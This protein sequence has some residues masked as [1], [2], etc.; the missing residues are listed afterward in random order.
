[1][2]S[3]TLVDQYLR[4][5]TFSDT[6]RRGYRRDI[7]AFFKFTEG[8]MP[9]A[10]NVRAWRQ[11]LEEKDRTS[12]HVARCLYAIK[13]F[14]EWQEIPI[15]AG[16]REKAKSKVRAPSLDFK[17]PP[18]T[19]SVEEIQRMLEACRTPRD[20]MMLMFLV[21]TGC[22]I[23]ELMRIQL[24]DIDWEAKTVAIIRKGKK[25]RRQ[26][27][28]VSD[29]VLDVMREWIEWRETKS[30]YLLPFSYQELRQSFLELAKRAKVK[31]PRSSLFHNLRHFFVLFQKDAGTKINVISLAAG[32]TSTQITER[33]Y[34]M[35]SPDTIKKQLHLQP[36]E[37]KSEGRV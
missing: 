37:V 24:T 26:I 16:P 32:H 11:S 14:C 4:D 25:G 6:T 13:G 28:M 36:W 9:T 8:E 10:E 15:F 18:E 20:K 34:G 3:E 2:K 19:R 30:K 22:R 5:Q 17:A 12:S 29:A 7:L 1:M 31:F 33:V 35:Q 21:T 27:I 23:S